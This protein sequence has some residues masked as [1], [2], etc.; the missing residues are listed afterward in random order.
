[1]NILKTRMSCLDAERNK[2]STY[3]RRIMQ[4]DI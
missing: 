3:P 2:I 1:M 4:K